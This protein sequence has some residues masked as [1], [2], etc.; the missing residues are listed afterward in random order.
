M[1][2]LLEDDA[3]RLDSIRAMAAYDE[4]SFP[5]ALLGRYAKLDAGDKSAAIQTLA[6]R[7]SYGNELTAAI[8]SGA[9]PRRDVPAY[10][11][12]QL[13][14]VV[15][16]GFVDVWGAVES[17]SAD[18]AAAFARYRALLTDDALAKGNVHNGRAVY[19]RTCFACHKL[20]GQGGEIGP[21]ITG[22]NRAN[23]DYILENI[24]NPSGEIPEGYQLLL[25]TTRGGQTLAGTLASENDQQLV[26]RVVGL[27]PVTVAKSEIQSRE[28]IPT[29]MMPEGLLASLRDRDVI[30][31]IR[32][33]RTTKQVAKPE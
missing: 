21:D 28:S 25:V 3:L 22:S 26:L 29:S 18:K 23:L 6:S 19:E 16:P 24:L 4:A 9:V 1:V 12:R 8:Q 14:R 30:D 27:P 17:L 5:R 32:Y 2:D 31:L 33:L 20:Y 13:R 15:G 7:P 10:V 11:V